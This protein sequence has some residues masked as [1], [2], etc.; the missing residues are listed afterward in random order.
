MYEKINAFHRRLPTEVNQDHIIKISGVPL[1]HRK[2]ALPLR[3]WG[4]GLKEYG[5]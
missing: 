1:S 4:E 2:V 3:R 5:I